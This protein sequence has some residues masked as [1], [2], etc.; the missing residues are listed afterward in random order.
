MREPIVIPAAAIPFSL[1]RHIILRLGVPE[2]VVLP[3]GI[4][5][6]LLV[7]ALLHDLPFIEDSDHVAEG[8]AD[9]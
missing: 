3:R 5:D 8:T 9:G 6:Q 4:A 7:A 1:F 2:L